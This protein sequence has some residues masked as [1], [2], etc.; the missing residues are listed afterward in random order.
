MGAGPHP[1]RVSCVL[2]CFHPS[3]PLRP[4]GLWPTRLLCARDSPGKN[5]VGGGVIF[6]TQGSNPSLLPCRRILY[7]LSHLGLLPV[8]QT[9]LWSERLS[10]EEFTSNSEV[11]NSLKGQGHGDQAE[12]QPQAR[13]VSRPPAHLCPRPREGL[14]PAGAEGPPQSPPRALIVMVIPQASRAAQRPGLALG[15]WPAGRPRLLFWDSPW[16]RKT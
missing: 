3:N 4:R 13:G 2:R 16:S 5:A 10:T 7:P 14:T 1:T 15:P 8:T 6:P 12:T 9:S 11:P